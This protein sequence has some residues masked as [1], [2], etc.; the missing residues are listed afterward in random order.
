M[1]LNQIYCQFIARIPKIIVD[2]T[3]FWLIAKF[4]ET[5]VDE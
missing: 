1:I 3:N 5:W 4:K 2:S